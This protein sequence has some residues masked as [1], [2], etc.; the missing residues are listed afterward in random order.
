MVQRQSLFYL[1]LMC[2]SNNFVDQ[3]SLIHGVMAAFRYTTYHQDRWVYSFIAANLHLNYILSF[4]E[5][6]IKIEPFIQSSDYFRLVTQ[7]N[8]DVC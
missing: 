4:Q 1:Q 5:W 8:I 2:P 7:I 6:Y 3:C